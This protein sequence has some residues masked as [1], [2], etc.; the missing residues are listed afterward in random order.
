[1]RVRDVMIKEVK[2]CSPDTN[3][4]AAT[5]IL[6]KEGVGA[7]PVVE[8]GRVL[9]IIT[10]RDIA[11][12]LGTRD[13]KAGETLVRDVTLP[14]LFYCSPEDD[15]HVALQT[16]RAQRVRRLPVLDQGSL[17]G[18]LCFDD[19]VL[20]AEEKAAELT[21]ADVVETMQA[22]CEHPAIARMLAVAR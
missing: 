8:N 19:I 15:I 14:K 5:E 12:A 13:A 4:G 7:L 16:M 11:V 6:W 10:D 2:F 17:A 18:I 21:H 9:G 3:L 1:M 20:Y 22:I